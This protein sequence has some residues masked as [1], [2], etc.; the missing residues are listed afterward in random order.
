MQTFLV[1]MREPRR[2]FRELGPRGF[3][4]F[5]LIV[6]GNAFVALVHPIFV[7][8][9]GWRLALGVEGLIDAGLCVMSVVAG[10]VPL[11]VLAWRGLSYR[12]VPN[13]LRVLAWTPLHWLLQSAAAW[14]AASELTHAP[15]HWNKTEHGFDQPPS[16]TSTLVELSRDVA[17]LKK[18][19]EVPQIWIDA[20][21]SAAN[22]RRLPQACV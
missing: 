20:T 22:R 19:G 9:F 12:G 1:Y 16:V 10:Y 3:T 15:F 4:A 21:Y 13:K 11:A 8:A 14:R 7:V 2:S 6:G 5:L 18:R 17:D